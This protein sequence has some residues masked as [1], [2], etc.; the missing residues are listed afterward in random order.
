MKLE[1]DELAR[2]YQA[3]TQYSMGYVEHM[4]LDEQTADQLYA[5]VDAAVDF[6]SLADAIFAAELGS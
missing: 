1:R 3:V 6:G 5:I 2:V 4:P